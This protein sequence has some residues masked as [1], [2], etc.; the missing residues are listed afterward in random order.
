[1]DE[2]YYKCGLYIQSMIPS[3]NINF[4]LKLIG[5]SITPLGGVILPIQT[6]SSNFTHKSIILNQFLRELI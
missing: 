4:H 3:I 6:Y 5:V 2:K 1:M